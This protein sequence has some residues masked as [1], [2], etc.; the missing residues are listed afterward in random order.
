M[1]VAFNVGLY[2]PFGIVFRV[3]AATIYSV[4]RF[5]SNRL[6]H[7]SHSIRL[8][9]STNRPSIRKV[10]FF[11]NIT[12]MFLVVEYGESPVIKF[13]VLLPYTVMI[14][15]QCVARMHSTHG[16]TI[17]NNFRTRNQSFLVMSEIMRKIKRWKNRQQFIKGSIANK[18][19]FIQC[20]W[21]WKECIRI[22]ETHTF[23]PF[24]K[25]RYKFNQGKSFPPG[26]S[27]QWLYIDHIAYKPLKCHTLCVCVRVCEP[28]GNIWHLIAKG[29]CLLRSYNLQFLFRH[30]ISK[31]IYS[32]VYN[33]TSVTNH[34]GVNGR[35]KTVWLKL[36][37]PP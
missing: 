9:W 6:N 24:R 33:S 4:S 20:L 17:G 27:I 23:R 18:V 7:Q 29:H 16:M 35:K 25:A 22:E 37:S 31:K 15:V 19:T 10:W 2:D 12:Y 1:S 11:S 34:S 32:K 5:T 21:S 26:K 8:C 13:A 28:H 30:A 36:Y 14:S 3:Y